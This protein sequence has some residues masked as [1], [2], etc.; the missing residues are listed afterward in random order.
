MAESQH[1]VV[2]T[3]SCIS[4]E[5]YLVYVREIV[6]CLKSQRTHNM[7]VSDSAP[8][9]AHKKDISWAPGILLAV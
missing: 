1:T 5:L 3:L 2:V 6:Y 9:G 8:T 4:S 7:T